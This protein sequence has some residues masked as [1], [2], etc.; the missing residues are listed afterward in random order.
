MQKR[1]LNKS[2]L[3]DIKGSFG[4]FF[5]ILAI[6]FL[7]VGFFSGV[8]ITTPVM[9]H[10]INELYKDNNFYD[11]RLISTLG[12]E[13]QDIENIQQKDKVE[14]AEGAF[15]YDVICLDNDGKDIVL[16]AHSIT[17]NINGLI[18]REGRLPSAPNEVLLD[19]YNRKGLSL[20]DTLV[21]SPSNEEDTL[22]HFSKNKYTVV[23][24]ADSSLYINFERGNT[25]LGN[26]IVDG[27][28]YMTRDAFADDI[29][30]EIYVTLDEEHPIYSDDY[31]DMMDSLRPEWEDITEKTAMDRYDRIYQEA[32]DEI[33]EAK[34][35][36]A[37][38]TEEG[39]KELEDAKTELD[40]AKEELDSAKEEIDN[41]E[42]E[43]GRSASKLST[44]KSTL[45]SSNVELENA[46]STLDASKEALDQGK[47]ELD[48]SLLKIETGELGLDSAE[49]GI[50]SAEAAGLMDKATAEASRLEIA[51]SR[52][53]LKA[54]RDKYDAGLATYNENYAKYEAGMAEYESGLA[55][56]NEGLA[57]YNSGL[58]AYNNGLAKLEES[59]ALYEDGLAEYEEGLAE[60]EDGLAEFNEKITEAEKEIEDA[61]RDLEDMDTPD[62]FVLERNSNIA[63]VCFNSDSDIVAQVARIFP[64]FFILV[65][66]LVCMTTM[67]RMVE[68]QRS[69]IGTLKALGY[70]NRDIILKY[71]IYAGSASLI[72]CIAGYASCIFI[73]P[74][75]IWNTYKMMYIL[76]PLKFIFNA[77]LALIAVIVSLLCSVGTTLLSCRYELLESAATLMRPK[78]P[79]PGR[80]VFLEYIPAIWNRMKFLHKVSIRNIFRYK[81]RFF[82]MVIGISGC[83]ALVLT[84]FGMKDSIA[85]FAE[86]QYDNIQVAD[87]EFT[88]NNGTTNTVPDEIIDSLNINTEEYTFICS[89][90]Y[91]IITS[92]ASKAVNVIA[93]VGSLGGNGTDSFDHFFK[94]EEASG[95]PLSLPKSGE[96]LI[97]ISL[98]ERYHINEGD[99]IT[100]RNDEMNEIKATVSG[101]FINH[102]YNYVILSP[103]DLKSDINGAY[104]NSSEESDIYDIQRN[105]SECDDAVNVSVFNDFKNRMAKTMSSLDYIVLIVILSAAGLA[106]VVL[107]NLTNIN[108]TE[109]IREIATIKVLGF[110]PNETSAYV[111]RENIILTLI[112]TI[113]GLGLGV[114]LHKYVMAQIIVDMVYFNTHIEAISYVYAVILTFIFALMV[115]LVMRRKLS[116]INMAESLKSVE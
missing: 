1:A 42:A 30:T 101:I 92:K 25:S 43:L 12:W 105:L 66:A 5:A 88:F 58:N 32:Y 19:N 15:Q 65:A 77:K 108:I 38:E 45:D 96:I 2:T 11:Y 54:A 37:E 51:A 4:R 27:F 116:R 29:Y 7:G 109:R 41:G 17:D 71:S 91:D 28:V 78:A 104:I 67:T 94:L 64:L 75:V 24:F 82:M 72:G 98:A 99:E 36:L 79:K 111:F 26:G 102:V 83:T 112:G 8:R 44:A 14:Y 89:A 70:S 10:T 110:Y 73:F 20:G 18:L 95:N 115:N 114:L 80:R 56:Y 97:S 52:E 40:D 74:A 85:G 57:E 59:K 81:R 68:E 35:T 23:G 9:V 61:E 103:D 62:T 34:E 86:S 48:A 47:A 87:A 16:R 93:P 49:A 90:A 107:Y 3:R 31:D 76:V 60:Y 53:E 84:G 22:E 55:A 13:D 33:Q 63:Y 69:Q 6:T 50:D 21:L 39:E 106:F 113:V 100:L 46:K